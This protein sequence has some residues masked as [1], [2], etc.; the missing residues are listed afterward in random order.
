MSAGTRKSFPGVRSAI[1]RQSWLN[2]ASEAQLTVGPDHP[3]SSEKQT[4]MQKPTPSEVVQQQLDAYNRRD[5]E[6]FCAVFAEDAATFD[7]GAGSATLSGKNQILDRYRDLFSKSPALHSHLVNRTALGRV[8]VDLEQITGRE[9]SIEVF[10][11]LAIYEVVESKIKR[12][13]FV[14]KT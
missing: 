4:I 14:R 3:E 7:L 12:V 2:W 6:A 11:V 8:V 13:H 10:E 5:I 1:S 9:G